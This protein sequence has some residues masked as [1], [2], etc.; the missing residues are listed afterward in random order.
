MDHSATS[1][2]DV[3]VART[4]NVPPLLTCQTQRFSMDEMQLLNQNLL[5]DASPRSPKQKG[6][7]PRQKRPLSTTG[8]ALQTSTTHCPQCNHLYS[9]G[10][11]KVSCK[12]CISHSHSPYICWQVSEFFCREGSSL[13]SVE[14]CAEFHETF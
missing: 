12:V 4:E 9:T 11:E 6:L 8:A 2:L 1:L 13:P 14:Q 7:S 3:R 10:R 5:G